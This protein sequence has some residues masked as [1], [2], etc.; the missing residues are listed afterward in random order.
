MTARPWMP[1]YIADYR[2][3]TTR[4]CAAEHGAYLLLIMEYWHSGSLPADDRQL[5]RVACMTD[6]EWRKAKPAIAPYFQDGW[7]H[8]R[9]DAELARAAEISSKRRAS[10]L[11]RHSKHDA[12]AGANAHT[13]HTPHSEPN[14]SGAH[15]PSDPKT[16]LFRRGREILGKESGGLIAKLL[17]S[18]GKEDDPKAIAKARARLE[19][20]STKANPAEWIGRV[21]APKPGDF[22]LMSNIEG[23]I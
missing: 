4:L 11:Q 13:L 17:K 14:G 8:K 16:E 12:N 18:F 3:D 19:D 20:A 5:A 15:A 1:L 7:K 22:K 2:A 9:I 10:A 21:L 23:V 6:K